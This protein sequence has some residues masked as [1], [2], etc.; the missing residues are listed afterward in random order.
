MEWIKV[1]DRLPECDGCEFLVH[2][3]KNKETYLARFSERKI[4]ESHWHDSGF[5]IFPTHWAIIEPPSDGVV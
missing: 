3:I 1:T 5:S 2:D 4:D